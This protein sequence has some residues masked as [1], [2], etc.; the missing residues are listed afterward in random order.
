MPV[1][2]LSSSDSLKE[3]PSSPDPHTGEAR[4]SPPAPLADPGSVGWRVA[5]TVISVRQRSTC[6]SFTRRPFKCVPLVLPLSITVYSSRFPLDARVSAGDVGVI[7]DQV[8]VLGP[9]GDNRRLVQGEIVALSARR[10]DNESG[11]QFSCTP[12]EA[13]MAALIVSG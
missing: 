3:S 1:Q 6:I 5:A 10:L 13:C 2:I 8:A 4:N 11:D 7:E 12:N 9:G